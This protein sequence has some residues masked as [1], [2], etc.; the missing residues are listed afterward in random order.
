MTTVDRRSE[1]I[2]KG[3]DK[4][5]SSSK[6]LTTDENYFGSSDISNTPAFGKK[7]STM[8]TRLSIDMIKRNS[9]DDDLLSKKSGR[10]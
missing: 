6:T 8:D 4:M 10:S 2:I 5:G 3:M 1:P 7:R 9:K